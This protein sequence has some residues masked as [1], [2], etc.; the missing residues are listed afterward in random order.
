M[1]PGAVSDGDLDEQRRLPV[2]VV[3]RSL[4]PD[5]GGYQTQFSLLLPRLVARGLR[6]VGIGAVHNHPDGDV[7]WPSVRTVSFGAH[8]LPRPMRPAICFAIAARS[9]MLGA[10]SRVRTGPTVLLLLSPTMPGATCLLRTWVRWIGPAVVR[11]PTAGDAR[12]LLSRFDPSRGKHPIRWIALSPEQ[13]D[14][15]GAVGVDSVLIPNGVRTRASSSSAKEPTTFVFIGRLVARKRVSLLIEAWG[16]LHERLPDWNVL[17]SGDGQGDPDACD[18]E[19]HKASADLPRVTFA[20]EQRNAGGTLRS[21]SILVHPSAVEGL[22][23]TV[24]E[25]MGAGVPVIADTRSMHR[26]FREV[27][28]HIE[29]DGLDAMSLAAAMLGAAMEDEHR[30]AVAAE[31]Q[32]LVMERYSVD[33][34]AESYV[35]LIAELAGRSGQ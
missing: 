11:F 15:L 7:G 31:A 12:T 16:A 20:G 18:A 5:V 4:P 35:S 8:R 27:P 2:V 9:W 32:R 19:L 25:A 21:G 34:M 22:P 13:A 17:I 30:L 23:N 3:S 28:A 33:H 14:E 29:W 24:L 6:V 10:L 1:R 26:W